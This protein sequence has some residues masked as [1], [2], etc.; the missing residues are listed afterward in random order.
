MRVRLDAEHPCW[1]A[2]ASRSLA[3]LGMTPWDTHRNDFMLESITSHVSIR[4]RAC[5]SLPYQPAHPPGIPRSPP[6]PPS[7]GLIRWV[8]PPRPCRPSKFRLDVDA[9][10]SPGA[11]MSSFMPR[12]IEHPGLRHSKPA[13]RKMRSSPSASAAAFTRCEPGTTIARTPLATRR[14]R[15]TSGG[16][17][18]I[19]EP[20]VGAGA[21]KDPIHPQSLERRARPQIHVL[22]RAPIGLPLR[23]RRRVGRIGHPL[24]DL[25]GHARAGAPGDL[26]AQRRG[27]DARPSRSYVRAGIAA[28]A[29]ASLRP[30]ASHASPRGDLGRERE[31]LER[32][33]RRARSCRPARRPRWTCCRPSSALPSRARGSPRRCTPARSRCR[34]PCRCG[35]S[36]RG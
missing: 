7:P 34:P 13:S 21:E 33:R 2:S 28:R 19:A 25:R 29:R 14:P 23:F 16:L 3:P 10:R 11:R 27:V 22:Q 8:R 36:A 17:A 31:K 35:G 18:Q 26:R 6:P 30:R 1:S 24:G 32:G 15:T 12:H 5:L 9:Q 20:P 4:Y